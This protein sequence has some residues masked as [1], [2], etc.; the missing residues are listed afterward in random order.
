MVIFLFLRVEY[1]SE[2]KDFTRNDLFYK[3]IFF[4]RNK[5]FFFMYSTYIIVTIHL[6]I[7]E[8][9]TKNNWKQK[10]IANVYKV[11]KKILNNIS[12]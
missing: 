4:I 1:F 8:L 12:S 11:I 5:N 2:W 7:K 6:D 10:T 9:E 3:T